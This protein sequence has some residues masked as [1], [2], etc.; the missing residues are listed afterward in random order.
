MGEAPGRGSL[1][2]YSWLWFLEKERKKEICP[3]AWMEETLPRR[4]SWQMRIGAIDAL[5]CRCT[6]SASPHCTLPSPSLY[7]VHGLCHGCVFVGTHDALLV[8]LHHQQLLTQRATAFA[9][10]LVWGHG[11]DGSQ[12]EDEGVDVAVEGKQERGAQVNGEG[13][14]A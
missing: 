11:D 2:S 7:L 12:R 4:G 10:H 8:G 9:Q 13:V 3:E 6:H 5:K 1:R 14:R